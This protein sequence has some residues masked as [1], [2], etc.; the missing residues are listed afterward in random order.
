MCNA[1]PFLPE[2]LNTR[3][4]SSNSSRF[5]FPKNLW[6][7][8]DSR[9]HCC[10]SGFCP[11]MTRYVTLRMAVWVLWAWAR[12]IVS[13]L[14]GRKIRIPPSGVRSYVGSHVSFHSFSKLVSLLAMLSNFISICS[15]LIQI[16]CQFISGLILH[17]CHIQPLCCFN[18]A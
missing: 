17:W 1:R 11:P 12:F 15:Q 9:A 3:M 5:Q 10:T 16:I 4:R 18:D 6:T 2:G 8:R 14:G 13:I 7:R